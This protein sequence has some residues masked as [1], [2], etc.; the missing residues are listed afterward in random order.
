[1]CLD[2]AG[3]VMR[4]DK[5]EF[6]DLLSQLYDEC[7][8][9]SLIVTASYDFG[10]LPNLFQPIFLKQL[11]AND[12]VELFLENCGTITWEDIYAL[13]L[14][15]KNYPYQNFFPKNLLER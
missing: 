9:L 11:S 7:Q 13:I 5:D 3:Q 4:H 15:D 12:S 6:I 1:M 8:D 14:Q 10:V 2:N